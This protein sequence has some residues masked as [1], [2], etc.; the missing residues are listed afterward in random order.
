MTTKVVS[1]S[2]HNAHN[3][4]NVCWLMKVVHTTRQ[5]PYPQE[6]YNPVREK[7]THVPQQTSKHILKLYGQAI[8][9]RMVMIRE[10]WEEK[11]ETGLEEGLSRT[12]AGD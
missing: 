4:T 6:A 8:R 7:L 11:A 12:H 2:V 1:L 10:D 9:V 5:Y 3:V